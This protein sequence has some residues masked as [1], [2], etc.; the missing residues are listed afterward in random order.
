M[1]FNTK[2]LIPRAWRIIKRVVIFLFFFQLF[3][4][5]LLKWVNPP[6]TLTELGSWLRGDGLKHRLIFKVI[7]A[8]SGF[9]APDVVR[10]DPQVI[11]AYLGE[12]AG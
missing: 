12:E 5:L 10:N 11:K 3:Y 1:P 8:V 2:G 6:V 4:L 7:G 9:R